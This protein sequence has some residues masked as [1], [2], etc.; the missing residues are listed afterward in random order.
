MRNTLMYS[1]VVTNIPVECMGYLEFPFKSPLSFLAHEEVLAFYQSYANH[2][3]LERVVKFQNH[4]VNVKPVQS[5]RWEVLSR[6]LRTKTYEANIFDAIFICNGHYSAPNIPHFDGLDKFKGHICHSHEYRRPDRYKDET[7]LIIGCGP[8]GKD[9]LYEVA[10]KAKKVI[11]SHN[12]DTSRHI[13]PLNVI[14][15]GDVERFTEKT[16]QFV[17]ESVDCGLSV[18]NKFEVTPLYKHL[19][20]INCTTMAIVGLQI[21]AYSYMYDLQA[22]L[23]LK[24]WNNEIIIPTKAEML[25]DFEAER[26]RRK[27]TGNNR[28]THLLGVDQNSYLRD[29]SKIGQMIQMPEVLLKIYDDC[30]EL[31]VQFPNN[32]RD[33]NY[34]IID[35]QTFERTSN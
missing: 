5:N 10:S 9:I 7:V 24:F 20:N 2:Y 32:Y 33:F 26:K 23:C 13:L 21:C 28:Q 14:Q 12:R 34:T 8:S 16:V 1:G 22:R 19:I 31:R 29:I 17:G 27:E 18:E 4:V 25:E 6:D 35:D 15:V 3:N 11:F 30:N